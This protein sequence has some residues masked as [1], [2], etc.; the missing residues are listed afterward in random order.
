MLNAAPPR[1]EPAR[2][3]VPPTRI[4]ALR[5]K[6]LVT[7]EANK[8]AIRPAMYREDVKGSSKPANHPPKTGYQEQRGNSHP[9][10]Q[11]LSQWNKANET[12]S[13][14][15]SN[16]ED[17]HVAVNQDGIGKEMEEDQLMLAVQE[18]RKQQIGCKKSTTT[19]SNEI[20]VKALNNEAGKVSK[21]GS[22]K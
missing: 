7:E 12:T 14:P 10:H 19:A 16:Q 9:Q 1:A 15:S 11:K 18:S 6:A 20:H 22:E 21:K 5:P 2:K 3:A 8:E 13:E 4:D 17:I